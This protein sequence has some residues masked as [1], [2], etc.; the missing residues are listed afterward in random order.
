MLLVPTAE[1]IGTPFMS[2]LEREELVALLL[3][4]VVMIIM[5]LLGKLDTNLL[6]G[7]E[8]IGAAFLGSKGLQGLL[9]KTKDQ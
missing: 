6:N 2:L 5:S 9:P 4:L 7:I 1:T 3:L 8:W